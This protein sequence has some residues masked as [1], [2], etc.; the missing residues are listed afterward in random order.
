HGWLELGEPE[1]GRVHLQEALALPGPVPGWLRDYAAL[2]EGGFALGV[3]ALGDA[4]KAFAAAE[5]GFRSS[6]S[7]VGLVLVAAN[8]A[9]A[10]VLSGDAPGAVADLDA[11]RAERLVRSR[12]ELALNLLTAGLVA[13]ADASDAASM[14][15]LLKEYEEVRLEHPSVTRDLRVFRAVARYHA[16]REEWGAAELA[17]GRVVTAIGELAVGWIDPGARGRFLLGQSALM[18]E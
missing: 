11:L 4:R 7:K 17:Y 2:L 5:T 18:D 13:V 16:R 12:P 3:R 8:R 6:G 15:R 1:R 10:G 14:E 9:I